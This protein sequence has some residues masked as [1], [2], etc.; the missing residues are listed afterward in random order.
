MLTRREL[1]RVGTGLALSGL[2]PA[3]YAF[4][5]EPGWRLEVTPYRLSLPG[6]PAGLKLRIAVLADLH[7][8]EPYMGLGRIRRI[9]DTA[10]DLKPDVTVVLGDYHA[11]HHFVS[12]EVTPDEACAAMARLV[13]PLG[14][15]AILGNH[16][17]WHGAL[18]W[19]RALARAGLQLLENRAV[20]LAH[21]GFG[22][23][24][25]GL[26]SMLAIR[27]RRGAFFGLNNL[28]ATLAQVTD[29]APVILL[30]HE[31][32][33]FPEVPARVALTL[34]GHTHGG[35]VRLLGYSPRVP[36]QFGN[37]FAYGHVVEGGRQMIVSGGLGVSVL[38]VRLG[39]PPEVLL[40]EVG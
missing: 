9:V 25:A 24:L 26:A 2:V 27:L 34:A 23:W 17:Y 40:V 15:W 29:D 4:G 16:D 39:V 38:P 20:R 22:F 36:S 13:A 5:I 30:A 3:A 7:V 11:S 1:A 31:P 14:R 18:I 37:R 21:D 10:N 8:G 32:D 33:I 6:W 28:P 35:Q 19:R 12:R